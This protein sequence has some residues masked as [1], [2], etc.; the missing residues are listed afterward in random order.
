MA[1]GEATE[2]ATFNLPRGVSVGPDGEL[3]VADGANNAVRVVRCEGERRPSCCGHATHAAAARDD[4][5]MSERAFEAAVARKV[6]RVTARVTAPAIRQ[7]QPPRRPSQTPIPP[8]RPSIF[9]VPK[10]E[11]PISAAAAPSSPLA[12]TRHAAETVAVDGAEPRAA[13]PREGACAS[14]DGRRDEGSRDERSRDEGCVTH[15][16]LFRRSAADGERHGWTYVGAA[17]AS[18]R[19]GWG[20]RRECAVLRVLTNGGAAKE[21]QITRRE[22]VCAGHWPPRPR[23]QR[24]LLRRRQ[25]RWW[26]RRSARFARFAQRRA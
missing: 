6:E 15:A 25:P 19:R 10:T 1:D 24:G 20:A 8:F 4:S 3:W 5:M 2:Q 12:W 17:S 13:T 22:Q 26:L 14:R 21:I 18:L 11:V 16:Q 7:L 9:D 23:E